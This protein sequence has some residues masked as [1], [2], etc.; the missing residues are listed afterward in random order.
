[1]ISYS[2]WIVDDEETIRDGVVL[3]LETDY[4]VRGFGNAESAFEA[5]PV[6]QPDLLLLDIGLPGMDG[7]TALEKLRKEYPT[8][9]VVIIT[10]Y[11]DTDTVISVMKLGAHDFV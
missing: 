4:R 7:I 3:A 2:I 1:M 5:L 8:L 6:E 11:E 10:A 9:L